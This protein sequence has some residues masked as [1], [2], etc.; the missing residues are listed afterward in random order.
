MAVSE[1][2][3]Y[4][5]IRSVLT[6]LSGVFCYGTWEAGRAGWVASQPELRLPPVRTKPAELKIK[7]M[8]RTFFLFCLS[9]GLYEARGAK[10]KGRLTF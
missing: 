1:D 5:Q 4:A 9:Y 8:V 6:G 7:V 2:P 10:H 3:V